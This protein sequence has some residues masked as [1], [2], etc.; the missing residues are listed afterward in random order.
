MAKYHSLGLALRLK[1]SELE[2]IKHDTR[3]SDDALLEVI[4][5]WLNRANLV[6]NAE[7]QPSSWRTLVAAVASPTGGGNP[8]KADAIAA[9]HP[10]IMKFLSLIPRL[11]PA[12]HCYTRKKGE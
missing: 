12:F 1:P 8:A 6:K 4:T 5:K 10:G 9:N 3:N 11:H 2:K 7:S